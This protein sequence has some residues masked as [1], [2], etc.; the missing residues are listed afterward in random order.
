MV[1]LECITNTT[2]INIST[3]IFLDP[4]TTLQTAAEIANT[5]LPLW[6]LTAMTVLFI[7]LVWFMNKNE[8]W[9]LDIAQSINISSFFIVVLSYAIIKAGLSNNIVSLTLYGFIW[10][11][12]L[13]SIIFIKKKG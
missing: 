9:N 10:L 7:T 4:Q 3:D 11:V 12:S 5:N 8:K 1:C 6:L 2:A 13:I